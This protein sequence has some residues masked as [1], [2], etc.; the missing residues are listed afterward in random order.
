M[1]AE[2]ILL[3][4]KYTF[5]AIQ[6]AQIYHYTILRITVQNNV[7]KTTTEHMQPW[8]RIFEKQMLLPPSHS[9][10]SHKVRIHE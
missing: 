6:S 7:S 4:E 9:S 2:P 8:L 3:L 5:A 10:S 1:L